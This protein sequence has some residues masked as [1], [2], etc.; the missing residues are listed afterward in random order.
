MPLDIVV[1]LHRSPFVPRADFLLS[2]FVRIVVSA[3][4]VWQE[5]LRNVRGGSADDRLPRPA[6]WKKSLEY[7]PS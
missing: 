1:I 5:Q 7:I 6:L 3:G 2:L 4:A